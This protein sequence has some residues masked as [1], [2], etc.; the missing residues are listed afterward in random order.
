MRATD[1][2]RHRPRP[3]PRRTLNFEAINH[4]AMAAL[5][6]LLA[7]WLPDGKRFGRE[8]VA[9]NPTRADR[10]AGSFKIVVSGGRAGS[11]ADFATGH[12]GGDP[13]SLAAYLFSLSQG[14]AARALANMLGVL[15]E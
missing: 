1:F 10:S 3:N 15:D 2:T 4:A 8:Y 12:R 6:A 5:P 11:W 13:I 9:R 7:R 14:D